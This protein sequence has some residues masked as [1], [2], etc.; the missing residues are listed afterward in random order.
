MLSFPSMLPDTSGFFLRFRSRVAWEMMYLLV[1]DLFHTL[2]K[3][4]FRLE[5]GHML[6]D[7]HGKLYGSEESM[8]GRNNVKITVFEPKLTIVAFFSFFGPK[9]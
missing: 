9:S 1:I 3:G 8:D 4:F 5:D 7:F 6:K 2:S